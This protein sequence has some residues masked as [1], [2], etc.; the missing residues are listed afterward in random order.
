[1]EVC[2]VWTFRRMGIVLAFVFACS[3]WAAGS[4]RPVVGG[5]RVATRSTLSI[6]LS[7]DKEQ[8]LGVHVGQLVEGKITGIQSYGAFVRVHIPGTS[9]SCNGLLHISEVSKE[10]VPS[11]VEALPVGSHIRCMVIKRDDSKRQVS[12]STKALESFPG[13]MLTDKETVFAN[14]EMAAIEYQERMESEKVRKRAE[15][16]QVILGFEEAIMGAQPAATLDHDGK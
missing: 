15:A 4:G 10:R 9:K 8:P 6:T 3:G 1:V 7:G 13:E 12:L 11:L 5:S 2:T 16:E 14:A